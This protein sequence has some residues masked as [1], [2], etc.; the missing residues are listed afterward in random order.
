MIE[1]RKVFH[2]IEPAQRWRF[3]AVA[4]MMVMTAALQ[5]GGVVSIMPFVGLVADP[6][7]VRRN[8]WMSRAYE[9]SGAASTHQ[10]LILV[11]FV[12]VFFLAVTNGF[13]VLSRWMTIRFVWNTHRRLSERML[14]RYLGEPYDFYLNRH[15]AD[16]QKSVLSDV[17]WVV[18][19]ILLPWG[20]VL[21]KGVTAV[22]IVLLLIFV[23]PMLALFSAGALSGAYAAIHLMI[24]NKQTELGIRRHN[25]NADKYRITAEA[26]GGIKDAKVF[27]CESYFLTRFHQSALRYAQATTRNAII[28]E[29]PRHILETIAFGG[30]I[31]TII[32]LLNTR[33][34]LTQVLPVLAL[35]A[36]A[37]YRLIPALQSVFGSLNV[38]RFYSPALAAVYAD[39]FHESPSNVQVSEDPSTTEIQLAGAAPFESEIR[40]QGVTFYY[41]NNEKPVLT[42]INLVIPFNGTVGLVGSTGSG[43]T[44]IIDLL[45]GLFVP[46]EGQILID[47]TPLTLDRIRS[48]RRQIGYVSQTIF[49]RDGTIEENIAFGVPEDDIDRSQVERVACAAHLH[50]FIDAL[51]RKYGTLVGERGVRLSGGER[52]RIAIARA[53]YR[54][55]DVLVLDE[56]TSALDGSTEEAVMEAIRDL[57]GRK[58]IVLVAHRL[59]TVKE[60]DAIYMIEGGAVA[61]KGTFAELANS[62]LAFRAMARQLSSLP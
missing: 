59:S 11:G 44:T 60:C 43:K 54:N 47:G 37:G 19:G 4:G 31:V 61:A 52:Q 3:A 35:Y 32:Y 18:D 9:L 28:G 33:E 46:K 10:F 12:T 13:I 14:N 1:A 39:L 24:R 55:P 42:N 36:L 15:T 51:P 26:F 20:D 16:L 29:L 30:V 57:S 41:P 40:F 56:A 62:N 22:S 2:L 53:L 58:T 8:H 25:A 5:M 49:L 48:W 7:I 17:Q 38:I 21:A 50:D 34:S 45:L 6:E 23:D 27:E